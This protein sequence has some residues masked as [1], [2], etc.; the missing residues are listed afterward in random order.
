MTSA[1]AALLTS[2]NVG[3]YVVLGVHHEGHLDLK[4]PYEVAVVAVKPWVTD[5]RL[6]K[7]SDKVFT[8]I[9]KGKWCVRIR[10][11]ARIE[12]GGRVFE[13]WKDEEYV[14]E[15]DGCVLIPNVKLLVNGNKFILPMAEHRRILECNLRRFA[16]Y[17]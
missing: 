7:V 6:D 4:R 16:T 13:V 11:L 12:P 3:D 2:L 17:H 15:G 10:W 8:V 9:R 1:R 14:I 5:K